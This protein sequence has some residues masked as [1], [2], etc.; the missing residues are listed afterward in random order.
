MTLVVGATAGALILLRRS[1]GASHRFETFALAVFASSAFI[2]VFVMGQNS[3]LI[4]LLV[5][6]A[7]WA[8]RRDREV[9]AGLLIGLLGFKPNWV[10]GFVLWLAVTRRWRTLGTVAGVGAL[11]LASTVPMG[12][13]VWEAFLTSS[14]GWRSVVMTSDA[15]PTPSSRVCWGSV[16]GQGTGSGSLLKRRCWSRVSGY[17]CVAIAWPSRLP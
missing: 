14:E 3:A 16:V 11:M 4:L 2:S 12:R 1:L 7:L 10:L 5:A 17:G 9:L 15:Y 8:L 13:G 6:G